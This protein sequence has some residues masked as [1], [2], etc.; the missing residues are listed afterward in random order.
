MG[1]LFLFHF[2][3]WNIFCPL[4]YDLSLDVIIKTG[5]FHPKLTKTN[6]TMMHLTPCEYTLLHWLAL[7]V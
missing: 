7:K 4:I 6:S 5:I 2:K 3:E 1:S